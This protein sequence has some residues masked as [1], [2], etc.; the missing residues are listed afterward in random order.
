MAENNEQKLPDFE[1]LDELTAFFDEN[2]MGDYLETMP[3]ADFSVDIKRRSHYVAV[4]EEIADQISEISK[5]EHLP[6]GAIVNSWLREKI[7]D[8]SLKH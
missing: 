1:S 3:E 7:S 6:S 8:Y 4:D 2:D 5:N